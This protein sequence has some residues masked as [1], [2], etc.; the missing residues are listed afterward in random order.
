VKLILR[1]SLAL[2]ALAVFARAV[3]FLVYAVAG[4]TLPGEVGD[5][6]SKLVHLAWR[7][8]AGVR[9]YPAWRDGPHVTNFFAPCYFLLTGVLGRMTSASL[10]GLFVIGRVL[11]VVFGLATA[12]LLGIVVGR[13]GGR[14]EGLVAAVASLGAAP[15]IGAGLM[16]RPDTLAELLGAAG[17]FLVLE[18]EGRFRWAGVPLL[19]LAV[20][21]KQTAMVYLLAAAGALVV[22]GRARQGAVTLGVGVLGA[23]LVVFGVTLGV[24]PLF[25]ASLLGE[26][27][28]PWDLANWLDQVHKLATE[29][30]DLFV[31]PALALPCWLSERPRRLA[32]VVLWATVLGAGLLTAGKL[33]SG[34]NYFLSLRLIEA[35]AVGALWKEARTASRPGVLAFGVGLAA[36]SVVPGV[37]LAA[38]EARRMVADAAFFRSPEGQRSLLARR[39]LIAL[40]EDPKVALLTDSGLLQLYQKE[41]APFVDPFQFRLFVEAGQIRPIAMARA[42]DT[43]SYDLVVTTTDLNGPEYDRY[44]AGL[45]PV[46]ARKARSQYV[47]QA[48]PIGLYLYGRRGQ[49][50]GV[51]VR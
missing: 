48:R 21:T 23:A 12:A 26:S 50:D 2:L 7:V 44:I 3:G 1:L 31:I 46:L 8:Q 27:R 14:I 41:R 34:L 28:T 9:L 36:L 45:P 30:P 32:P 43:A 38:G 37:G 15:M 29:S 33:G 42:L 24:E 47:L 6:E 17:F 40:A 10:D 20:L 49:T 39:K 18:P 25:A 51:P 11:T 4:L 22:S 5:L 35:L 13:D 16:V 19:I